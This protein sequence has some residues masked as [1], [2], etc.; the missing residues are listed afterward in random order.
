MI[1]SPLRHIYT[2]GLVL[3]AWFNY[4][5]LPFAR[6]IAILLIAFASHEACKVRYKQNTIAFPIFANTT[7]TRN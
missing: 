2:V 4:C 7:E 6:E 1:T 5:V 3:I